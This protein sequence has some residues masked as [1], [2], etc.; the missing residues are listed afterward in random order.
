MP[1]RPSSEFGHTCVISRAKVWVDISSLGEE[2]LAAKLSAVACTRPISDDWKLV[3]FILFD[4]ATAADVSYCNSSSYEL[5]IP[6][7]KIVAQ[8]FSCKGNTKY[9]LKWCWLICDCTCDDIS[10]NY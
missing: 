1:F 5:K 3:N 4:A 2:I 8:G 10:N 6:R 9:N 7:N